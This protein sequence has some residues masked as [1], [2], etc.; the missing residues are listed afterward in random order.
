MSTEISPNEHFLTIDELSKRGLSHYKINK[1]VESGEL[2]KV[3]RSM[4]ENTAYTGD[5]SDFSIVS[6]FA[7]KGVFCMISAARYYGLTTYLP[8]AVDVA[9]ER[10]MKISTLPDWPAVN[11]WYFPQKRYSSGVTDASD[12][13]GDFRIYNIEKTVVDILYYRNKVGIEETKE[14]LKNY[15]AREDRDLIRLHR[16]ADE[17]GCRKILGTYLE[18]LI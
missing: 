4:Y 5:E 16:Y 8:D 14:I 7:P 18:V 11:I 13:S 17:L 10:S 3:S 2:I 9:I 15:L 12:N 6:A 1:L